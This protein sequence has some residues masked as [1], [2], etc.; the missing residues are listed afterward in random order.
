M[1]CPILQRCNFLNGTD[2]VV[3]FTG[4]YLDIGEF[5]I[6]HPFQNQTFFRLLLIFVLDHWR[7]SQIGL[8]L[9]FSNFLLENDTD[10]DH[11][12][13]FSQLLGAS[14]LRPTAVAFPLENY[15]TCSVFTG[16]PRGEV[17]PPH[18]I[19]KQIVFCVCKIYSLSPALMFIKSKIYTG[20]RQ[21]LDANFTFCFSFWGTSFP[22]PPTVAFPLDPTG[23]LASPRTLARPRTTWTPS[24]V[25][26]WVRLCLSWYYT[27]M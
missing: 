23:G 2:S 6:I 18:W 10:C 8:A 5:Y 26:S 20:K 7:L 13:L 19:F 9:Q 3:M 11:V 1:Y 14:P 22:R 17:Q 16:I 15:W 24:I 12:Q 27:P 21:K 4:I 25:K